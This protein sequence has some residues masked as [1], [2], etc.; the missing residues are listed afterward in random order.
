MDTLNMIFGIVGLISFGFSIYSHFNTRAMKL[1]E[2]TKTAMQKE[3]IRNVRL[4][5]MGIMHSVDSIVQIPKR[6]P[7][8]VEE[9]QNIARNTRAQ[10]MVLA[11]QLE[12]EQKRLEDW[13]YGKLFDS[14]LDDVA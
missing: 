1:I 10:L 3:Q 12:L 2:A 6:D 4:T 9:L 14:N 5:V 7:G 8:S 11:K 13:K